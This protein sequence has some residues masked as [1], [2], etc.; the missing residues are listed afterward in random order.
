MPN[1]PQFFTKTFFN[2][3]SVC[4]HRGRSERLFQTRNSFFMIYN[5]PL[6]QRRTEA[7]RLSVG[8][9]M[10]RIKCAQQNCTGIE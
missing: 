3:S 4:F 2:V 8:D 5:N 9:L 1:L 10:S 7:Y 6:A